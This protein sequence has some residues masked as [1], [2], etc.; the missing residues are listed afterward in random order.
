MDTLE[1]DLSDSHRIVPRKSVFDAYNNA[2][3]LL[4]LLSCF[5]FPFASIFFI[6]LY[7]R[8]E[9]HSSVGLA[10]LVGLCSGAIA[11]GVNTTLLA[12]IDRYTN[13]LPIFRETSFWDLLSIEGVYSSVGSHGYNLFAWIVSRFNDDH[14]LRSAVTATFYSVLAFIVDD[15]ASLQGWSFRRT[16]AA[17]LI[18]VAIPPFF[19]VLSYAKSTPAFSLLLLTLYLDF[20]DFGKRARPV[21][22]ILLYAF[23]ASTHSSV[24]PVIA[25]RVAL[26]F[27]KNEIAIYGISLALLP[28]SNMLSTVLPASFRTIPVLSLFMSA[29]DKLSVYSEFSDWGWAAASQHSV[30]LMGYRYY[31]GA[32]AAFCILLVFR[33]YDVSKSGLLVF[34]GIWSALCIAVSVFFAA[35]VFFRYAMPCSTLFVLASLSHKDD[36]VN[37]F[38]DIALTIIA[39]IGFVVQWAYLA[40]VADMSCFILHGLFGV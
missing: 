3:F 37:L 9:K 21:V 6:I 28:L 23:A 7:I 26:L 40:S 10:I 31:F 2:F 33:R 1:L 14:L 12:D 8:S 16:C 35:D 19:N 36:T 17:L 5:P 20:L 4:A 22:L 25:L 39:V 18:S 29:L 32:I 27:V 13:S 15:Y 11:Y 24:L 34:S 38:I 30:L